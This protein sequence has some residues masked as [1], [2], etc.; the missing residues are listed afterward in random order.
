MMTLCE[1]RGAFSNQEVNALHAEAFNTPVFDETEW[2]WVTLVH[3]HRLG[4]VVAREGAELVGFVNVLWDGLVHAWL[5]DTM[6]AAQARG[7]GIGT[8][9]VGCPV[10]A[11]RRLDVSTCTWTSRTTCAPSTLVPAGSRPR[12]PGCCHSAPLHRTVS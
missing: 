6:V 4:W 2:N 8:Q 1:W 11:P 5:Q 3:R 12:T 9:L 10:M 7:R